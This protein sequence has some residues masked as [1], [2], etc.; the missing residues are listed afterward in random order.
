MTAEKCKYLNE[1]G[2]CAVAH[3]EPSKAT[4]PVIVGIGPFSDKNPYALSVVVTADC[5]E[6]DNPEQQK[7]C[8][9]YVD[10]NSLKVLPSS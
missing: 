1:D 6:I 5:K 10:P 3:L 8:S 7:E 4:P 9:H 2:T